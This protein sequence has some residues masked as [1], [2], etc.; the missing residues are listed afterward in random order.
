MPA[1][2][3]QKAVSFFELEVS[4]EFEMFLVALG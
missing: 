3:L 1:N 2:K 4:P